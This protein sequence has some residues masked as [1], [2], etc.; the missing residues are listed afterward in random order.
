MV[1]DVMSNAAATCHACG[2]HSLE[3]LESAGPFKPISSDIQ[4][5]DG[6][7]RL[8]SCREC[9]L[10]Q[11]PVDAG[12]LAAVAAVY[13]AY[14]INH[15]SG[16]ADPYIFNSLYGAGPRAEILMR[17]LQQECALPATG[18]LLDIGCGNGNILRE[19]ARQHPDWALTGVDGSGRWG[20]IVR[21]IPG[22]R[23]FHAGLEQVGAQR[24]DVIVMSH[25]LEHIADPAAYLRHL[26][27]YLAPGGL[28]F[29]AVP[30]IRQNPIDLFVLD[31]CTHFDEV[32]LHGILDGG[33]FAV[34]SLRS[35]VLGKEIVALSRRGAH[36]A[37][38]PRAFALSLRR[39][40]E[41]YLA[42]SRELLDCARQHRGRHARFG[43]MGT[44]TA[45]AWLTAELEMQVDFYV[46]EDPERIGKL[47][48]DK[49]IHSLAQG[50]ADRGVF[51]PMANDRARQIIARA[52]RADLAF[53]FLEN[54]DIS[55]AM[56][57]AG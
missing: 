7:I 12:W 45:A 44:S 43:I 30:D 23:D 31:H 52:N 4:I 41:D 27:Q 33:G 46:D 55:D 25:V 49:P 22:V 42:L 48:F 24:Y 56:L 16:G 3:M 50:P 18:H 13:R 37:A 29:V 53:V 20:E 9:G 51:I 11:K 15:Q 40:G 35:D 17:H 26:H 14:S 19:F 36:H 1:Q 54:N 34:H 2:S 10:L 38:P 47:A 8:A 6:D 32:T 21:A 39:I 28:L 5:V 57:R